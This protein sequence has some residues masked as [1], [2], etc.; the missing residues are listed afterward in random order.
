MKA[1]THHEELDRER[2]AQ[3]AND[4]R[5]DEKLHHHDHDNGDKG[6]QGRL[7]GHFVDVLKEGVQ[8]LHGGEYRNDQGSLE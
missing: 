4:W 5:I 7:P 2:N 1:R 6:H 3:L 8:R